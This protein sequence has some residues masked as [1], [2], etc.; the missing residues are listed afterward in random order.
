[1]KRFAAMRAE[2]RAKETAKEKWAEFVACLREH[3]ND[4]G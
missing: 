4:G 1:M 2:K 3:S